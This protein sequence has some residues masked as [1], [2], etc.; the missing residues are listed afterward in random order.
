MKYDIAI[1]G[2]GPG[3]YVAAIRA[4]KLGLSVALVEGDALGG[5][6]LNR[7]CIPSKTLLKHAD[8]LE[9][10]NK[11]SELSIEI[12]HYSFDLPKIIER[13]NTVIRQLKSGIQSLLRQ[14]KI[15]LYEGFGHVTDDKKVTIKTGEK[16]ETISAKNIIL[17]TG[18]QV[19]V[20]P[21]NGLE[22]IDYYTSDTI[23][24]I[25]EVPNHLVI[26]GGGVIG[27]EIA[28]VF[29]AF[30][31]KVEIVEMAERILPME[32]VEAS[33]FLQKQLETSGVIFHTNT[34]VTEFEQADNQ[35]VIR[36][37]QGEEEFTLQTDAVLMCVGRRPNITGLEALSVAFDGPFVKVNHKLETSV[38]GIYAI[39]DVIGGYQLAHAAS[40]EGIRAVQHIAGES[41][42]KE[43]LIPRCVYTFPEIASVGLSEVEAQEAG[44]RVKVKKVDLAANGKA[45]AANENKGFMKVIADEKY[46]EILGVVMVGA[47]VTEMISQATA[48]MHLEGTVEEMEN[49]V[50]PHPTVSEAMFEAAS[51]YLNKGIHYR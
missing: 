47:H 49:M 51:A 24:D 25:K 1:V 9:Q 35:K 15:T 13:K 22:A 37:E 32:D 7:G 2:G 40:N 8:A 27:L 41:N 10:I 21:I 3:G 19:F 6:C 42:K 45:I 20:P 11:S 5:T 4:A 48:F 39:G 14:N 23:F 30:G 28:C 43:A 18:S 34:K 31:T 26:V 36:M 44:Y 29:Q 38:T 12:E 46:N 17:A 16:Q 33:T 50:F